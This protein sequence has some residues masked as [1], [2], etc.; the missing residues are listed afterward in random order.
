MD[1]RVEPAG[2][3]TELQADIAREAARRLT[4]IDGERHV[5]VFLACAS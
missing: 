3:S 2:V 4:R 1:A 5:E